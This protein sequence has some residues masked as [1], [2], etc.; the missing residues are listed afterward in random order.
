M[1]SIPRISRDCASEVEDS[2]REM[3]NEATRTIYERAREVLGETLP[4]GNE[5]FDRCAGCHAAGRHQSSSIKEISALVCSMNVTGDPL[6]DKI[7]KEMFKK[8]S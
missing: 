8:F 7:G 3:Y 4:A 6:L 5:L 1:A 2:V